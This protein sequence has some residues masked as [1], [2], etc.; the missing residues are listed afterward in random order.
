MDRCTHYQNQM[1]DYVY[2]LLDEDEG[3]DLALHLELCANCQTG[4]REARGQQ[5]LLAAAARLEFPSV[6][7]RVPMSA[8]S[9]EGRVEQPV[10]TPSQ[11]RLLPLVRPRRLAWRNWL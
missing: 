9:Q 10:S 4:L 8:P 11:P 3:R 7:F 5:Q 2:D 6:S 1:L